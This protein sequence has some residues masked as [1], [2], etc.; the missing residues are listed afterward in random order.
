VATLDQ[1]SGGRAILAVGIGAT[2]LADTGE[3]TAQAGCTW[4]RETRWTATD[5]V[6]VMRDRLAAGPPRA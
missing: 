6:Q 1:L 3:V 4:W 5:S 2:G